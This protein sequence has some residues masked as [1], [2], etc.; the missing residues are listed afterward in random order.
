MAI[1]DRTLAFI[2]KILN[3]LC[4]VTLIIIAIVRYA[5]D[6]TNLNVLDAIWTFYWM[7]PNFNFLNIL[8]IIW[9]SFRNFHFIG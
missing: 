2:S 7:Y 8:L 6:G 4:A 9:Q 3:I 1:S 5:Y